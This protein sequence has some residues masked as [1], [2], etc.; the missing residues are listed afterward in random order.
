MDDAKTET[1]E[2]IR[3]SVEDQRSLLARNKHL[4]KQVGEL[5][6]SLT[7][8]EE[9]LRAHRRHLHHMTGTQRAELDADLRST[10]ERIEKSYGR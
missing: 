3:V 5:Q 9:H 4:E 1:V 6:Q 8:K 10:T 7:M 2:T